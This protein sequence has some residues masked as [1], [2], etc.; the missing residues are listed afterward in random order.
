MTV[1]VV[2]YDITKMRSEAVVDRRPT[3]GAKAAW[4]CR[5]ARPAALAAHIVYFSTRPAR[6][7]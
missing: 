6:T 7:T 5:V 1:E 2:V 3:N 4:T